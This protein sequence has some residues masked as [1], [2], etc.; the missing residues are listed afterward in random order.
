VG[1]RFGERSRGLISL[2]TSTTSP[3]KVVS[4]PRDWRRPELNIAT[5][6]DTDHDGR[7]DRVHATLIRPGDR[8]R[9]SV[10]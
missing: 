2:Q 6:V 7:H 10:K 8:D 4:V 1:Q 9:T 3:P 5:T